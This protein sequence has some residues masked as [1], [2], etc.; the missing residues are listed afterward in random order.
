[1]SPT[2]VQTDCR[3]LDDGELLRCVLE[4]QEP[5]WRELMRRFRPLI[6]RCIQRVAWRHGRRHGRE[7]IDEIF[8]EVCFNLWRDD[9]RKLRAYDPTRGSKLG[10]WL[11][12]IAINTAYDELRARGRRPLLDLL[13]LAGERAAPGPSA[14][15]ELLER[16]RWEHLFA[17]MADCTDKDRAFISLYYA[18][19]LAPEEVARRM[20]ISV[21]TVYSK[22]NKLRAR[23]EMLA[24]R[25]LAR[26]APPEHGAVAA[27]KEARAA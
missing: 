25:C 9:L 4:R 2:K 7:D 11:G 20:G 24:Q 27:D 23:L 22:K 19:G 26:D 10:S 3:A 8:S 18:H 21:K 16:E 15:D 14:L 6:Y 12:L 17:L 13:D 1:M 5:A